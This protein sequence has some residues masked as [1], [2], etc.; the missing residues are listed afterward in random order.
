MDQLQKLCYVCSFAAFL[1]ILHGDFN[2]SIV[3][4][5]PAFTRSLPSDVRVVPYA[6]TSFVSSYEMHL[7]IWLE[8]LKL[9]LYFMVAQP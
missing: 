8:Y 6:A 3:K 9:L 4:T 7:H 2:I 5:V 1:P